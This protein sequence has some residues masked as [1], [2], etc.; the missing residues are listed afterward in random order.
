MKSA[1]AWALS[2]YFLLRAI[3]LVGNAS[4]LQSAVWRAIRTLNPHLDPELNLR[5]W[6]YPVEPTAFQRVAPIVLL[7]QAIKVLEDVRPSRAE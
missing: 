4:R 1:S 5:E 7:N 3:E 2:R 6:N